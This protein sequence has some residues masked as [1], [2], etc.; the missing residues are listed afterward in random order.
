M[1]HVQIPIL[2]ASPDQMRYAATFLGLDVDGEDDNTIFAKVAAAV[3]SDEMIWIAEHVE[4]AILAQTGAAPPLAAGAREPGPTIDAGSIQG[5]LGS[6]DPRAVIRID[7]EERNGQTYDGD[8]SVGV[9]GRAWQIKR[10]VPAEVPWR[11]VEALKIAVKDVVTHNDRGEENVRSVNAYPWTLISG[12]S[13]AE[14]A[15]WRERT[16]AV[17]LP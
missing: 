1:K 10:G 13:A 4:P 9:N 7:T 5:T 2:D 6:D 15:A 3:G 14:I 11:V 12:P 17:P 16:D 8:V